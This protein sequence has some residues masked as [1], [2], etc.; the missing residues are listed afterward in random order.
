M[1]LRKT[2]RGFQIIEFKDAND[3]ECSLQQSSA[4]GN[5]DDSFDKPGSSLVWL[6]K[7]EE[8]MHLTREQVSDLIGSLKMWQETGSFGQHSEDH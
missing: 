7:G 3:K 5:Y 6:G 4:I 1:K 2:Q 8:R